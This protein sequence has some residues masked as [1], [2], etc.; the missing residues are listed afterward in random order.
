MVR[1]RA[2]RWVVALALTAS[3]SST[4][5][6]SGE[7]SIPE[8]SADEGSDASI[9]DS[10]SAP[11]A[12]GVQGNLKLLAHRGLHQTFDRDGVDDET[13][14][15]DRINP[16][17]HGNL[18]NTLPSVQAAFELGAEVVEIDIAPSSDGV[19]VVFHDWTVDCRT[20]GTGEVRSLTW[21]ELSNLDIGYGYTP[22]GGQTF[23]FRGQGIGLM[24]RLDDLL[25]AFPEGQFL[26]N[27]KSDDSAEAELLHQVIQQGD[28]HDQVWGV[29]GGAGAVEAYTSLSGARGFTEASARDCVLQY[30]SSTD[31]AA[32]A[33]SD[34]VVVVPVDLAGLIPGWPEPFVEDMAELGTHVIVSGPGGSGVDTVETLESLPGELDVYVWTDRIDVVG[35]AVG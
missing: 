14:T 16:V 22:D 32:E 25:A 15:A 12:Q 34:T 27:F 31:D 9:Q 13:C 5:N 28:A 29:Y 8:S 17:E 3:C 2:R 20:D 33:C 24:P 11:S 1:Y 6:G 4:S 30:M 19:L 26:I 7:A 10:E 18:E 23:P 35:P 21:E